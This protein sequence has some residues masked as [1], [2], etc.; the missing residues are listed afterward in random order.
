MT[1]AMYQNTSM[2]HTRPEKLMARK[3]RSRWPEKY[4]AGQRRQIYFSRSN[5]ALI[6][7]LAEIEDG[8]VS[9]VVAAALKAYAEQHAK[10]R[11]LLRQALLDRWHALELTQA[12]PEDDERVAQPHLL[13]AALFNDEDARV[14]GEVFN[15]IRREQG[16]RDE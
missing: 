15:T 6:D 5:N 10:R 4:E 1:I 12:E 14:I 8:N 11:D 7:N 2:A 3:A 9:A 16:H 13:L